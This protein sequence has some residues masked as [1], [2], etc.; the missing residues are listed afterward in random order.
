MTFV[1]SIVVFAFRSACILANCTP[2]NLGHAKKPALLAAVHSVA[3]RYTADTVE[4]IRRH[5]ALHWTAAR[6][7][8][9]TSKS[10]LTHAIMNDGMNNP[11]FI[12]YQITFSVMILRNNF[13]IIM[14]SRWSVCV[15]DGRSCLIRQSS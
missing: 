3:M 9:I 12:L 13:L 11:Q 14:F 1:T 6:M 8:V 2:S 5:S 4:Y 7:P 15:Y 10:L